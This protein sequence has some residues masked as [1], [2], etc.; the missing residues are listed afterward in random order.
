MDGRSSAKV[1]GKEENRENWPI[2]EWREWRLGVEAG[3]VNLGI[4]ELL[5]I[6][7]LKLRKRLKSSRWFSI[8]AKILGV[9]DG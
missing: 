4:S 9:T 6:N 1:N 8:V 7:L 5:L 2:V 3:S